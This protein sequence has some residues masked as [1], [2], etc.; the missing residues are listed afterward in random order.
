MTTGDAPAAF[1]TILR[2]HL[3]EQ[4]VPVR[5]LARRIAAT[6]GDIET[7]RRAL[8][9]YLSGK[10]IPELERAVKIEAALGLPAGTFPT[11]EDQRPARAIDLLSEIRELLAQLDQRRAAEE[12]AAT[13]GDVLRR[14]EGVEGR[15]ERLQRATTRSLGAL[16]EEVRALTHPQGVQGR[17][18]SRRQ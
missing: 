15:L 1:G 13:L 3:D 7:E 18:A 4:R 6:P 11:A 5:E 12:D 17:P 10:H 2:A 16:A 14:L 9:R 8:N